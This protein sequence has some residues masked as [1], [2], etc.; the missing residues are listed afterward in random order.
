MQGTD[1]ELKTIFFFITHISSHQ[2]IR[3]CRNPTGLLT[4]PS[5]VL[6]F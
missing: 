4:V 5:S 3:A 6:S 1:N 2:Q